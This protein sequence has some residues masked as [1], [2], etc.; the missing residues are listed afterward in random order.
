M[1]T[2][3]QKESKKIALRLLRER[4]EREWSQQELADKA[5]IDRKTVNRIENLHFSPSME[6]FLRL[7][8][9]MKVQ[10]HEVLKG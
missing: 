6:T 1:T 3:I 7:C 8:N 2:V 9:A 5:G 4:Q 10:A